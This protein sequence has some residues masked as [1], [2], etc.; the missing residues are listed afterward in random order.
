MWEGGCRVAAAMYSPLI[1]SPQRVSNEFMHVT[2]LLP[3]LAA[4]ANITINNPTL[5]GFNQWP[6]ISEGAP[7]A[8]KEILYNIENVFGYS[9]IMNDGWKLVNGTDEIEY[10]TWLGVSGTENVNITFESYASRLLNSDAAKSLPE[11]TINTIR[12]LRDEA[13]VKC[14]A[15]SKANDCNP[16]IAPCLFNI[17]DDPCEQNNL[18]DSH[19]AKAEFLIARLDKHI[20]EMLPSRRRFTDVA[21]DPINFNYTWNWWEEDETPHHDS[22]LIILI[23]VGVLVA[24]AFMCILFAK[25]NKKTG[26]LKIMKK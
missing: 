10:A 2:D 17:I 14:A 5:D 11:L 24:A 26:K 13:T 19:A 20:K 15:N 9:A 4:A 1:K 7:T 3:T 22:E 18:A 21:C 8:R 6:M 23:A 25:F 16:L 12:R